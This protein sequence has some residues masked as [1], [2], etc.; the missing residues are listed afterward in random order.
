MKPKEAIILEAGFKAAGVARMPAQPLEVQWRRPKLVAPS[1]K[2][3]V[4]QTPNV[5]TNPSLLL[6]IVLDAPIGRTTASA[7]TTYSVL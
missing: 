3:K 2:P 4:K 7:I 5:F 1:P 6:G